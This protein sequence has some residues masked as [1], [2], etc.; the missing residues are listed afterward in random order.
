M[1]EKEQSQ[2]QVLEEKDYQYG[3]HDEDTSVFKTEKGLTEQTIREIS[4][5]KKEPEWM[6]QRRLDAYHSF[7]KQENPDLKNNPLLSYENLY[8]TPHAAFYSE[9][10]MQELQ[11][12]SC[13]NIVYYMTKNYDKVFGIVNFDVIRNVEGN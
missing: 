7:L 6:L 9:T 2:V 10:S 3:F 1:A 12:I 11:R 5:I 8:L 13:E 4:A